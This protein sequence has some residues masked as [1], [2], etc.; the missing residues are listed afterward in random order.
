MKNAVYLLI[1]FTPAL[2]SQKAGLRGYDPV[3]YFTVNDAVKGSD[4]ITA[5]VS[6]KRWHFCSTENRERFL[7]APELFLPQFD[8]Y[9]AYAA[10]HN[11][12]YGAD[13][14]VW[15]IVNGKLYLNYSAEV[16]SKWTAERDTLIAAGHRNWPALKS[17]K[18]K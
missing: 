13:P 16:K 18:T 10:G 7:Q 5:E 9:C 15:T 8:G 4:T 2:F 1:L 6:G 11:Y 12:I 14:K 3:A 17:Q